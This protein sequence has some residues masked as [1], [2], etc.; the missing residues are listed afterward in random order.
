MSASPTD[1][2]ASTNSSNVT[3]TSG[4][5]SSVSPP[6]TSKAPWGDAEITDE[7]LAALAT[8]IRPKS[9]AA[10]AQDVFEQNAEDA[11]R[12]IVLLAKGAMNDRVRLDAAKYIVD[13]TLGRVGDGKAVDETGAP[14][15]NIFGSIVREPTAE[16]RQA[17]AA[18]RASGRPQ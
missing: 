12:E 17:G 7:E 11:A 13:R 10:A 3:S 2:P 1:T 6:S 4:T 16:E 5:A 15:D 8:P 9:Y 14:W 18:I